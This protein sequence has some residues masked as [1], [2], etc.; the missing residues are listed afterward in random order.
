M[1]VY[2]RRRQ[3]VTVNSVR[4]RKPPR[5]AEEPVT[6]AQLAQVLALL[7]LTLMWMDRHLG[8]GLDGWGPLTGLL[9]AAGAGWQ[10]VKMLAQDASTHAT[11]RFARLGRAVF[12]RGVR[13]GWAVLLLFVISFFSSVTFVSSSSA[14]P[15]AALEPV[16]NRSAAAWGPYE[17]KETKR[18][19]VRTSPFGVLFN[20]AVPGYLREAVEVFPAVGKRIHQ[21]DLR[22]TL[23]ILLR[24]GVEGLKAL[25]HGRLNVW[26]DRENGKPV[27]ELVAKRAAAFVGT[28]QSIPQ[29]WID[30]WDLELRSLVPAAGPAAEVLRT[31]RR[32]VVLTPAVG[33]EPDMVL[34]AQ[35]RNRTGIVIASETISLGGETLTDVYLADDKK[36]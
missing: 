19:V 27:A 26:L 35:I 4:A 13:G 28:R 22:Q 10:V 12:S 17:E 36:E 9:V 30:D 11:S 14:S 31:W 16:G 33:L 34:V 32:P 7:V 2:G 24:P 20:L 1:T 18:W 15:R 29:A 21:R 25:E 8:F 5:P 3:F 23:T 6:F